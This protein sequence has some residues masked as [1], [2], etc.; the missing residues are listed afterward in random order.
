MNIEERMDSDTE[1]RKP[2][3]L[4]EAM[5]FNGVK[6]FLRMMDEKEHL[7]NR[8]N[9]RLVNVWFNEKKGVT[10]VKWSDGTITKVTLQNDDVWD[11]AIGIG[12]CYIKKFSGNSSSFNEI[13][14]KYVYEN[15]EKQEKVNECTISKTQISYVENKEQWVHPSILY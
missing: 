7:K 15:E 2:K 5:E 6:S 4:A 1:L 12:F 9:P 10:V 14:R 13:L 3:T 11:K 8:L